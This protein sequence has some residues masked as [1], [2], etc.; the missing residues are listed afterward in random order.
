M[1]I[2]NKI[3]DTFHYS[4]LEEETHSLYLSKSLIKTIDFVNFDPLFEIVIENCIIENFLI[5]SCWFQK[6]LIFKN[7]HILNFIDYQMGGHNKSPI[8]ITGNIFNEFVNFFDCHFENDL[9]IQSN[10]F[11]KGTNL[12]GNLN[13]GFANTFYGLVKSEF[14]I[15]SLKI[16]GNG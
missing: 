2:K 9:E 5:L 7:N 3:I 15:G 10:I 13:E 6:G 11:F 14:N 12:F 8:I 4:E 1:E 16:D